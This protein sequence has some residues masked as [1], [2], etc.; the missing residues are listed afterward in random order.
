MLTSVRWLNR[1]LDPADLAAE[2]A[3]RVLEATCFPIESVVETPDGD[4]VLDVELTSNRGDC[5]SHLNLAADISALTGRTLVRPEDRPEA[6]E[7]EAGT[8]VDNRV[9][10][11]CPLF[12][13]RVIRNVKV[14]PSPD[15]L[16]QL[17]TN[18]GQ[19]P[20]NNI[21][22]ISNFALF[23]LGHPSHMFDLATLK[24][25]RLIVREADRNEKLQGLDGRVH[26]LEPT[27]LV[28]ADAQRAV[29]L[30]GIVGGE[31]TGVT[32]GTTE[33]LLEVAT[34]DPA[35]IRRTA[36]RLDIRTDAGYRFERIVSPGDLRWASDRITALILEIAGGELVGP[37]IEAGN[38]APERQVITLRESRCERLLGVQVSAG[39]TR[40][41][42]DAIG[43]GCELVG[44]GG[45]ALLRCTIPNR[46]P[47]LEREVDLIEEVG[48]LHG[49]DNLPM[50]ERVEVPLEIDHPSTW[51][52]REGAEAALCEALCG[53]GFYEA[54]TFSF[55]TEVEGRQFLPDG[56]RLIKVDEER[57]REAPFLRP[58]VIPSLLHSRRAN[59][60]GG[61]KLD[62]GVRLFELASVFADEDD[63]EAQARKT[64]ERRNLAMILDA[65]TKQADQQRAI[66]VMRTA[67]EAIVERLAGVGQVSVSVEP[68]SA[69]APAFEDGA[70]AGVRV[71]GT[72]LGYVALLG[73]KT[74]GSFGLETPVVASELGLAELIALYP[75]RSVATGLPRFPGIERDLSLL[76]D[77]AL[78]WAHIE[79]VLDGLALDRLVD[80]RFV[81]TFRGKPIEAG[82]KSVTLRLHFR[83]P[84][85]TLRH[86]EVD[87]QVEA[88][89]S[90][91]Q[92]ELGAE[93]RA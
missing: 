68:V 24:E 69:F 15:W 57:R 7:G 65:G 6:P 14:G 4:T 73:K 18:V 46:R 75:P 49:I 10:D 34:W 77:E 51:E 47:D 13:A 81:T 25:G 12:T 61:V 71:N 88:A 28:V 17:L 3:I 56:L 62:T 63:G 52:R 74:C 21:V 44:R 59:Q 29:S 83:D 20:I 72:H 89:V 32:E 60:D 84:E 2:E 66:R 41:L 33:V 50:A 67:I 5:F 90:A 48:R 76:V 53:L 93:L 36:R 79:A 26:Q 80:R 82:K 38:P 70:C 22:D 23:E 8:S 91:F 37:V 43:V 39:E 78:P 27:D 30:A 35:T 19:R 92:R 42:L 45:E 64:V 86:D 16:A 55:L 87:P 54:I 1:Y 58:S 9:P 11:R 85:R 40:R 31:E